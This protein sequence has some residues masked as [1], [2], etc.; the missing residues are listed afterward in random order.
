M[1]WTII[2]FHFRRTVHRISLVG[3]VFGYGF[4][5]DLGA[6]KAL[7]WGASCVIWLDII[8]AAT[9]P[10]SQPSLL[11]LGVR[12]SLGASL[13][14]NQ[15]CQWVTKLQWGWGQAPSSLPQNPRIYIHSGTKISI[16]AQKS[17]HNTHTPVF[18]CKPLP[19]RYYDVL[20]YKHFHLQS[21]SFQDLN[22]INLSGFHQP[23]PHLPVT[24]GRWGM[25]SQAVCPKHTAC[26]PLTTW[27]REPN[28]SEGTCFIFKEEPVWI[29]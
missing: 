28:T 24:Q 17:P 2:R 20:F 21:P 9:A 27:T 26:P 13:C 7:Q 6:L 23:I 12:L 15:Q 10:C 18:S 16:C 29:Q 1:C 11:A 5:Q 22:A 19:Q 4:G 3:Q 14:D 25:E 8:S